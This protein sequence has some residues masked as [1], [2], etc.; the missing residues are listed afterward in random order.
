MTDIRTF[1]LESL[2]R[3]G[4]GGDISEA[5]LAAAVPSPLLL[6]RDEKIAWK[7]LSH[8]ID[9]DDIRE[10]DPHYATNKRR[11]MRD[12]LANLNRNDG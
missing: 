12:H 1:L 11:R 4:G 6:R 8:W 9:D 7:E 5:E 2:D 3:V 10:R